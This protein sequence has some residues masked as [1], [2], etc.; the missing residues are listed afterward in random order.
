MT[1]GGYRLPAP[2]QVQF[3]DQTEYTVLKAHEQYKTA[4]PIIRTRQIASPDSDT[5]SNS[6][7]DVATTALSSSTQGTE[8]VLLHRG[9]SPMDFAESMALFA[10]PQSLPSPAAEK[11]LIY[12]A[13]MD[14][15]LPK[16]IGPMDSH[17]SF[18]QHLITTPGLRSEVSDS[19]DALAM[20]QVGSIYKD[21]NLLRQAVKAYSKSLGG[22][23][24]TMSTKGVVEDDYALATVTVLATCEFYDEIAQVGDGWVRHI[25]GSQQLLAARGPES[26]QS[27]LALTLFCNMR[28]G[29]L[30]HALIARKACFLGSPEWRAVAWRVPYVDMA[31]ILYDSALQVP[32][33]LERTDQLNSESP[34]HIADIDAILRD[35]KRL[36]AEIREWMADFKVRS[37]WLDPSE[38]HLFWLTKIGNFPTFTSLCSDRTI[39]EAYMFPSFMVAY[40]VLVCWD[41]QHFLR[42]AVQDLHKARYKAATGWFPDAED[43]V[44]EEE[45]TAYVM[46]MARC[47]PYMCEPVS[48]STGIIGLFLPLRTVAWHFMK[49]GNWTMLK[50]VGAVRDSVFNKGMSPPSVQ[51]R[52]STMEGIRQGLKT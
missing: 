7:S 13:F 31:T 38:P 23:V 16:R 45:L 5:D 15:Y 18:L 10:T 28:H 24:R 47:F 1:C 46:D 41:V 32:G 19:L 51:G 8:I 6:S 39:E 48:S 50:W 29:A 3:R 36:D 44:T 26:I 21:Q 25:E 22:L 14:T 33:V 12:S 34:D 20:V 9:E 17:F 43:I 2:G 52:P 11:S 42:S 27:D 49:Q 40:L 30:S 4:P 35:A 37:K